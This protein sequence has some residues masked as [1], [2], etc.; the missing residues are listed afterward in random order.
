[1]LEHSIG[2]PQQVSASSKHASNVKRL[3]ANTNTNSSKTHL[4]SDDND[5]TDDVHIVKTL[6][7]G[8]KLH[9]T[10]ANSTSRGAGSSKGNECISGLFAEQYSMT[11]NRC[12]DSFLND[13]KASDITR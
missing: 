12:Y 4:D 9:R 8:P 7:S 3:Y 2:R 13:Q 11:N 6:P 10:T 5:G 1:M